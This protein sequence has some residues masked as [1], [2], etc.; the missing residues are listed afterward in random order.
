MYAVLPANGNTITD[1]ANRLA[2]QHLDHV[3]DNE[4]KNRKIELHFPKFKL[5]AQYTDI[6]LD[7]NIYFMF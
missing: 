5:E 1:V 2:K 6:L 4:M 7:V 3:I